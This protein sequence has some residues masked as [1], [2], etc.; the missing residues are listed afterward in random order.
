MNQLPKS[1]LVITEARGAIEAPQSG[2]AQG[3]DA[4]LIQ[5]ETVL[6]RSVA[7]G[8]EILRFE[9]RRFFETPPADGNTRETFERNTT[10]AAVC[11]EKKRKKSVGDRSETKGSRSRQQTTREGAPPSGGRRPASRNG[12]LRLLTTGE[13][14]EA[15][16]LAMKC[17]PE[18]LSVRSAMSPCQMGAKRSNACFY[19]KNARAILLST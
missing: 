11:G 7:C 1:A 15:L 10:N 4:V 13:F 16:R 8:A 3:A 12:R 2:T 9:R 17:L 18:L 5:R 14:R 6:K 19:W